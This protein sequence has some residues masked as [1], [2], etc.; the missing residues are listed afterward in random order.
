MKTNTLP[1]N[2][3][4]I[5]NG[6]GQQFQIHYQGERVLLQNHYTGK[7]NLLSLT[8]FTQLWKNKNYD[9]VINPNSIS[10]HL[11]TRAIASRF[12]VKE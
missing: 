4:Y 11:D 5:R 9:T 2:Q 7:L 10:E 6:F 3:S 12:L 1:A 8:V